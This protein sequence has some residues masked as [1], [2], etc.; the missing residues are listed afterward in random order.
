LP[1]AGRGRAG[2]PGRRRYR[3]HRRVCRCGQV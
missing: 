3:L 1:P 2:H